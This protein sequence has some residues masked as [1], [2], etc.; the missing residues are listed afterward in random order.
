[1]QRQTCSCQLFLTIFLLFNLR[2]LE[3]FIILKIDDSV[4][5]FISLF[6]NLRKFL[7]ILLLD[8]FLRVILA[9]LCVISDS[10]LR[11]IASFL[12]LIMLISHQ[13][14]N[15]PDWFFCGCFSPVV[16]LFSL[17]LFHV[18]HEVGVVLS[19]KIFV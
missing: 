17:L 12:V 2:S 7:R 14:L 8:A 6:C 5:S 13:I 11:G 1:M 15:F 19:V 16:S 3:N 9:H 4:E 18:F 10:H